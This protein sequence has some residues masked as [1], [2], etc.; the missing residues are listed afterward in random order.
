MRNVLSAELRQFPFLFV[1]IALLVV[2]LATAGLL[3]PQYRINQ[4]V[5]LP[6]HTAMHVFSLVVAWLVFAIGWNTHDPERAGS[7]TR[8]ACGFLG[9]ALLDF[10]HALSYAGMPDLV[11]PASPEKSTVGPTG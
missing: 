3:Q 8:L 2:L 1:V 9:V 10:G 4:G 5:F 6:L 7:I 11:T